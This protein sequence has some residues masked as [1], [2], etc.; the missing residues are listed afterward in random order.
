MKKAALALGRVVY[1]ASRFLNNI[2]AGVLM[3]LMFMIVLDI[4]L[5]KMFNSPIPGSYELVEF[6]MVVMVFFFFA[7]TQVEKGHVAVDMFILRLPVRARAVFDTFNHLVSLILFVLITYQMGKESYSLYLR[8]DASA[9][10]F[11][12]TFPFYLAGALGAGLMA[13]VL[14]VDLVFAV[15]RVLAGEP[16]EGL[17]DGC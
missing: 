2:G 13:L 5:R 6:M 4:A 12:P 3:L 7:H 8:D 16:E 17:R 10:L 14:L 1:P 9:A 15:H 11:L